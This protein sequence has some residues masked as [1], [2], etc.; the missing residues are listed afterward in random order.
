MNA[1]KPYQVD[2]RKNYIPKKTKH[3]DQ[4]II[5]KAKMLVKKTVMQPD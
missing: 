3:F 2:L 4:I 5:S 1:F